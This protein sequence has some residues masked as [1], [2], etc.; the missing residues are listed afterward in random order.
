MVSLIGAG[1]ASCG[2]RGA[3]IKGAENSKSTRVTDAKGAK[4]K[5]WLHVISSAIHGW[6]ARRLPTA[7][8]AVR[9]AENGGPARSCGG[10]TVYT[11]VPKIRDGSAERK[12]M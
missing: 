11:A 7:P 3:Y 1:A 6:I 10:R 8:T 5:Q 9:N 4:V 2:D 12:S